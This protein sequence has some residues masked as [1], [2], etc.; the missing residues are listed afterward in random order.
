MWSFASSIHVCLLHQKSAG[1]KS[2]NSAR[3]QLLWHRAG[4]SMRKERWRRIHR[5]PTSR[6]S[7]TK[8][9]PSKHGLMG[10]SVLGAPSNAESCSFKRGGGRHVPGQL[11]KSDAAAPRPAKELLSVVEASNREFGDSAALPQIQAAA[12]H[13]QGSGPCVARAA[14]AASGYDTRAVSSPWVLFPDVRAYC[15][16]LSDTL[17][18]VQPAQG[19]VLPGCHAGP[20]ERLLNLRRS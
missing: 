13:G 11:V 20:H 3:L 1:A 15:C 2:G 10:G 14:E 16:R 5:P 4:A 8:R 19:R 6:A 17:P 12:R 7:A 18:H 9:H